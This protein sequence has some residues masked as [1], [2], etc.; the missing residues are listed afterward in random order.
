MQFV[1]EQNRVLDS[2]DFG[3]HRF[4]AFFELAAILRAGDHHRQVQH[5]DPF[6]GQDLGDF[7]LNDLLS[8]ALDDRR[9]TDA[10]FSQ[11]HRIVFRA[12]AKNLNRPLDFSFASDHRIE[13][14]LLGQFGQVATETIQGGRFAFAALARRAAAAFALTGA[15]AAFADFGTFQTMTEQVQHFFADIF[16]FQPQ[17]HQDLSGHAFLLSQQAQQDMLGTDVAVIQSCEPLPSST[18]SLS[19]PVASGAV[20]PRSPFRDRF[21]PVFR[22]PAES[23]ARST[24]RVLQHIGGNAAALFDQP[25]QDVLGA[26]VFVVEPLGLLVGQLHDFASAVGKSFVHVLFSLPRVVSEPGWVKSCAVSDSPHQ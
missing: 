21:G 24:S 17:V 16:Q 22:L 6:V 26:D 10:R 3:H 15:S 19:W 14:V 9:L 11:Q 4:D 2:A 7:A 18:R 25:Q 8:K 1:D 20:C 5:D 12:S 23:F 13:L